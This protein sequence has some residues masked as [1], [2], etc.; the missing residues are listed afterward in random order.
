MARGTGSCRAT[1]EAH[2]T[3]GRGLESAGLYPVH[4]EYSLKT[5]PEPVRETPQRESMPRLIRAVGGSRGRA[6]SGGNGQ[7]TGISFRSPDL[8]PESRTDPIWW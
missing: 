8:L 2:P 6:G 1:K 4:P 3:G 5:V 7:G